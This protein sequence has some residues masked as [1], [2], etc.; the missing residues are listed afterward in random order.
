L[1]EFLGRDYLARNWR[2]RKSR[3]SVV[4]CFSLITPAYAQTVPPEFAALKWFVVHGMVVVF[5]IMFVWA[6]YVNFTVKDTKENKKRLK[7]A[8]YMVRTFGGFFLGILTG[9]FK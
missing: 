2:R 6:C 1:A 4:Y 7:S 5:M 8:D 3:R 9:A